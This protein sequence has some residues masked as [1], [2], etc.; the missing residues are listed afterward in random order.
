MSPNYKYAQAV[1][2]VDKAKADTTVEINGEQIGFVDFVCS[3]IKKTF[4]KNRT[5]GAKEIARDESRVYYTV[6]DTGYDCYIGLMPYMLSGDIEILAVWGTVQV[7]PADKSTWMW[8]IEDVIPTAE[9]IATLKQIGVI[10]DILDESEN[11][12]GE[13]VTLSTCDFRYSKFEV[14]SI[15]NVL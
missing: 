9:S 8:Q 11:V 10:A 4:D 13:R 2:A 1:I 3:E 6:S 12:I 7:D 14:P 5:F 15:D